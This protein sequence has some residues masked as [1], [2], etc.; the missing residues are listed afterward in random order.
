MDLS[1]IGPVSFEIQRDGGSESHFVVEVIDSV[2]DY[3]D[4][5]KVSELLLYFVGVSVL[6]WQ[7]LHSLCSTSMP[8][9]L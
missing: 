6:I 7:Y 4:N 9:A 3:L 1:A 2:E 5:L 8:S